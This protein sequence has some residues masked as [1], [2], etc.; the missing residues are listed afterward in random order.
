MFW[1]N[2][3]RLPWRWR[4]YIPR[5]IDTFYET[6]LHCIEEDSDIENK[7]ALTNIMQ[8]NSAYSLNDQNIGMC[9][10]EIISNETD[11][12]ADMS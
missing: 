9:D 2:F 6:A 11:E 12:N 1:N 8:E 3:Y 10:K 4:Q 7:F 5:N